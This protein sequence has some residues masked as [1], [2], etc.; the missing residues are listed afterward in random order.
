MCRLV[1]DPHSLIQPF[2]VILQDTGAIHEIPSPFFLHILQVLAKIPKTVVQNY[3][4]H[5][6]LTALSICS[7]PVSLN[8]GTTEASQISQ[9]DIPRHLGAPILW[10]STLSSP[11]CPSH[12][13]LSSWIIW[14]TYM[15]IQSLKLQVHMVLGLLGAA[16]ALGLGSSSPVLQV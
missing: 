3:P 4:K 13:S 1:T 10:L 15:V 6:S 12:A 5:E 14:V 2:K 8:M 11:K 7:R 9:A 16:Y